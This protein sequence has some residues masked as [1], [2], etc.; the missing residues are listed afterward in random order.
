[1]KILAINASPRGEKGLTA[2]FLRHL[3]QGA[4]EAGA[5]WETLWLA[6]LKISPCRACG[7]CQ[8]GARLRPCV[9]AAQDDARQVFDKMAAADRLIF[10]TPIYLMTMTAL[11]KTLL[12]RTYATMKISEARLSNGLIH[13]HVDSAISSKP[14]VPLIVCSNLENASWKNAADYFRTYARF[15]ETRLAGQLVRNASALFD[16]DQSPRLPERFPK[17]RAVMAAY[18][19]AG[20]ELAR[21]GQISRQTQRAAN[22]EVIPVPLFGLLKHLPPV[23]RRVIQA[24][25]DPAYFTGPDK[26]PD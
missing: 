11:L 3:Q 16:F 17:T 8:A 25:N 22:Q 5:D 26:Q 24:L 10:A 19:R 23:K 6:R 2:F 12:E 18:R 9:Y 13:H 15:M 20:Q 14:F 1:M 21:H 4:V 7:H